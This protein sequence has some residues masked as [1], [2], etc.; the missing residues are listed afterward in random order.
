M[1][2]SAN[3]S[4][5]VY[6]DICFC[7]C[8]ELISVKSDHRRRA[9]ETIR[10][11]DGE[12]TGRSL[13]HHGSQGKTPTQPHAAHRSYA[14]QCSAVQCSAIRIIGGER[15][16]AAAARARGRETVAFTSTMAAGELSE[17]ISVSIL[18]APPLQS[19]STTGVR[20]AA[21]AANTCRLKL[22]CRPLAG[23]PTS[24]LSV[25]S[26]STL[27]VSVPTAS[28]TASAHRTA[29]SAAATPAS[30]VPVIATPAS[31][32]VSPP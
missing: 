9:H 26:C 27:I 10:C 12:I 29:S 32:F 11:N 5:T 30:A 15:L 19:S 6:Q 16:L 2:S 1:H 23:S 22:C 17:S 28:T 4:N 24:C 7:G 31:T 20:D 18:T 21:A 25:P 3:R 13:L 8:P 14:V